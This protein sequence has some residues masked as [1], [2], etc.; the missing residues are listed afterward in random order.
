M[1]SSEIYER[2]YAIPCYS[3]DNDSLYIRYKNE[4]INCPLADD[5]LEPVE[6]FKQFRLVSYENFERMKKQ[7]GFSR[8]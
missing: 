3:I 1:D 5:L 6:W 7:Y 8:V 4:T 2:G